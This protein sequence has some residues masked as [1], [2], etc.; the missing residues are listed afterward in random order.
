MRYTIE[1]HTGDDR[2]ALAGALVLIATRVSEDDYTMNEWRRGGSGML[3]N[4]G[5]KTMKTANVT[6]RINE[7]GL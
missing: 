4:A 5:H 1:I 7:K 6:Y 3:H 2:D